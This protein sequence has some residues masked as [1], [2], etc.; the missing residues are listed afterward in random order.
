[1]EDMTSSSGTEEIIGSF[2]TKVLSKERT[3]DHGK[4]CTISI[5]P[6]RAVL[7]DSIGASPRSRLQAMS[8]FAS[9]GTKAGQ[10]RFQLSHLRII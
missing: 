1:M 6:Y 8:Q 10:D 9:L 7:Y 5:P 4:G 2:G 3:F